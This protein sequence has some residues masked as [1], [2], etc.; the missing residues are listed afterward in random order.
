MSATYREE[1]EPAQDKLLDD[2]DGQDIHKKSK[3]HGNDGGQT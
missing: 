1:S 2:G 3:R